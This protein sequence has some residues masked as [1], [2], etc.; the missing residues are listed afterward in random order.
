MLVLY[1]EWN[2]KRNNFSTVYS[3]V[4]WVHC[5]R[6]RAAHHFLIPSTVLYWSSIVY[7]DCGL[8][9]YLVNCSTVVLSL[10]SLY[11]STAYTYCTWC[12]FSISMI[13]VR[14]APTNIFEGPQGFVIC[15]A[16]N[17]PTTLVEDTT[18]NGV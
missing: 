5:T 3:T 15:S 7:D 10:V 13:R 1:C 6:T 17:H 12:L 18:T 14:R 8:Y 4:N 11:S 9:R 16:I 2:F